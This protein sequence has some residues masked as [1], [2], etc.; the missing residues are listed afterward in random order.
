MCAIQLIRYQL[1]RRHGIAV[2]TATLLC[3]GIGRA[4]RFPPDPVEELRLALSIKPSA[5]PLAPTLSRNLSPRVEALRSLGDMRRALALQ[6]WSSQAAS[7]EELA[8]AER[9][10]EAL[11][12]LVDRF[13]KAIRQ[14]LKHGS[15]DG[16]LAVMV[17]LAEMGP[18]VR[19]PDP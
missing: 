11:L 3:A 19:G 6:D 18:G 14:V 2:L 16:R 17:M 15:I 13:K 4:D 5:P 8:F 7:A 10:R 9:K 1:L 12:L